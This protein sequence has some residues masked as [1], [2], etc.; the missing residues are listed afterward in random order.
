MDRSQLNEFKSLL[1][2]PSK[3]RKESMMVEYICQYLDELSYEGMNITYYLDSVNN[4]YVTKGI[5]EYYPCFVSHTDTVHEIDNINVMLGVSKKPS[6]FGK[7]FGEKEFEVL[8]GLNDE[9]NPTGIGGDDKAGIFICLQLLKKLPSCKA[10]FFVSEEIGC[11]G[12]SQADVEF[13]DDVT[14]V[15]QYDAPGDHLIT[16]ICSG[17]RL[18]EKQGEFINTLKPIIEECFGNPM[19]EQSHPFTDVMQLKNKLPISCINIS[20]GYYNMHTSKEFIVIDDVTRAINAGMEIARYG[21][22]SKFYFEDEKPEYV[23]DFMGDIYESDDAIWLSD[24]IVIFDEET[25][26]ITLEEYETGNM[27]SLTEK[28][29]KK[30]YGVLK[31]RY[32]SKQYRLF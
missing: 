27:V 13:F 8:Y 4:I 7:E 21:Y 11:I 10:A 5:S 30:L 12:S 15:C 18:Y 28:E 1:S 25:N 19:I 16:E 6:T 20:C 22:E 24:E 3:S 31:D 17:V 9:G 14:F 26:G 29:L 2:V 23:N 32:E